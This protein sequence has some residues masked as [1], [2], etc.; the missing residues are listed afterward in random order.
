MGNIINLDNF[1]GDLPDAL[2][3]TGTGGLLSSGYLHDAP[4]KAALDDGET[5]RF[6]VTSAKRGLEIERGEELESIRPSRGY[7]MV[8]VATDKRLLVLVG[9]GDG[10][11]RF[12]LPYAEIEQVDGET[13]LS[14]GR[15][16]I[17][18]GSG[19]V[20]HV[21]CGKQG[22]LELTAYLSHATQAWVHVENTLDEATRTLVTATERRDR[23]EYDAALTAVEAASECLDE[24]AETAADFGATDG[25]SA[26]ERRVRAVRERHANALADVRRSRARRAAEAGEAHWRNEAFEAAYEAYEDARAEYDAILAVPEGLLDEAEAIRAERERLDSV[27]DALSQSPL[28]LAVEADNAAIAADDPAEAAAHWTDAL[29]AYR[30]VL[31]LDW[32]AD[33]RRFAGGPEKI[34]DRLSAVAENLVAA[35]RTVATDAM[36]AGDWYADAGRPEVALEDYESARDAFESALDAA[37]DCYPDAVDHLEAELDALTHRLERARARTEGDDVDPDDRFDDRPEPDVD[38]GPSTDTLAPADPADLSD[39]E[40]ALDGPDR[41]LDPTTPES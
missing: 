13:G 7:R 11:S 1:D 32:G 19:A 34:R 27:V 5:P 4:A 39:I 30:A 24:A 23:G 18:R 41:G 6:V 26:L 21:H 29:E 17:R 22:L 36:E 14:H 15:C 20:W 9:D 10:D 33:E 37:R 40:R 35:R 28:R 3:E 25:A 12:A 2:T 16:T 8:G 31:E 38:V